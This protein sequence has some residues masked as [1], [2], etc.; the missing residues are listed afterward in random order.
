MNVVRDIYKFNLD[1]YVRDL[2]QRAYAL[3]D[4]V[5]DVESTN[6]ESGTKHAAKHQT[7]NKSQRMTIQQAVEQ[8]ITE[9]NI[10]FA[11]PL[12]IGK[13]QSKRNQS[14]LPLYDLGYDQ[15]TNTL[16]DVSPNIAFDDVFAQCVKRPISDYE[17]D[18]TFNDD[19]HEVM[20]RLK[21]IKNAL[22]KHTKLINTFVQ[23]DLS[24]IYDNAV[25]ISNKYNR[26]ANRIVNIF[27]AQSLQMPVIVN[28]VKTPSMSMHHKKITPDNVKSETYRFLQPAVKYT[29]VANKR[30]KTLS[31]TAVLN[32]WLQMPG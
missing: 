26:V 7:N 12:K 22:V 4:G 2:C 18:Y 14:K 32:R 30:Y 10:L 1:G 15:L 29:D 6:V 24:V 21:N 11:P 27:K 23:T 17:F 28:T 5:G 13:L 3:C 16:S 8:L 19:Y 9:D 31:K 20:T 25:K